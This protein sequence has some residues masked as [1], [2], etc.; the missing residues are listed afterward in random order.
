M[1]TLQGHFTELMSKQNEVQPAKSVLQCQFK[2]KQDNQQSLTWTA[3]PIYI[4]VI[5]SHKH[6]R[7]AAESTNCSFDNNNYIQVTS[8]KTMK[9]CC[10]SKK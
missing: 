5:G 7:Q 8:I 4:V 6:E 3:S 9:H 10:Y 2:K 1:L